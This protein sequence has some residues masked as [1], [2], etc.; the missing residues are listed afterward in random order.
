VDLEETFPELKTLNEL[1]KAVL[2]GLKKG[3]RDR[4]IG[5]QLGIGERKVN[6]VRHEIQRRLRAGSEGHS[7]KE[8]RGT[9]KP[10]YHDKRKAL[11]ASKETTVMRHR[12]IIGFPLGD[13]RVPGAHQ[14]ASSLGEGV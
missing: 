6:R 9:S 4:E 10:G 14:E 7:K 8:E 13:F 3:Y 5:E 1:Q 12:Q 11:T 2:E